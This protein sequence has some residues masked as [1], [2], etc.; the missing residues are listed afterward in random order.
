MRFKSLLFVSE[1]QIFIIDHAVG[2]VRYRNKIK[3]N[4]KTNQFVKWI[5]IAIE[6][7]FTRFRAKG[8]RRYISELSK[9]EL[10]K[11]KKKRVNE[12]IIHVPFRNGVQLPFRFNSSLVLR[13]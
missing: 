11:K 7:G 2:Y 10:K 5:P 12:I 13:I 4:S 6:C 9:I 1:L 3:H 8:R